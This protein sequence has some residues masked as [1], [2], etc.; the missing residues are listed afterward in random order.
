MVS[1]GEGP[2]YEYLHRAPQSELLNAL[3][4][5]LLDDEDERL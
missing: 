4:L 5:D 3:L 2:S 1:R